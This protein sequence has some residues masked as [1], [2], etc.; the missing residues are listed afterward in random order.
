MGSTETMGEG[1]S[2]GIDGGRNGAMSAGTTV[3]LSTPRALPLRAPERGCMR[4][5][6]DDDIVVVHSRFSALRMPSHAIS[7]YIVVTSYCTAA[8]R[9][10]DVVGYAAHDAN[11]TRLHVANKRGKTDVGWSLHSRKT[12]VV[13]V[14]IGRQRNSNRVA[15][16]G[17]KSLRRI[18][19]GVAGLRTIKA[20]VSGLLMVAGDSGSYLRVH[21]VAL[22]WLAGPIR[23]QVPIEASLH[24]CV[25]GNWDSLHSNNRDA[26]PLSST[27]LDFLLAT[28]NVQQTTP[29]AA[30]FVRLPTSP[31]LHILPQHASAQA[32]H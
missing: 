18:L 16:F 15:D 2:Q 27:Q 8:S 13:D 19:R 11:D 1:L 7:H 24:L 31:R 5:D 10:P 21:S 17:R 25:V 6:D 29:L 3:H 12:A 22:K 26:S 4:H 28:I 30:K 20:H 14:G 32:A 9:Q 23:I